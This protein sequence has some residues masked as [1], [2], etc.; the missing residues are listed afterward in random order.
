MLWLMLF[1][2]LGMIFDIFLSNVRVEKLT[3]SVAKPF[4]DFLLAADLNGACSRFEA[5]E[6]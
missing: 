5:N 1:V 2:V 3:E 6:E 4:P